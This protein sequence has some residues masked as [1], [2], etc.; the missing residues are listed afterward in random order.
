MN[1]LRLLAV[2]ALAAACSSTP[3]DDPGYVQCANF[4]SGPTV[5]PGEP[6]PLGFPERGC[7]PDKDG[8]HDGSYY[9]CCSDDPAHAGLA[10]A[11][12]DSGMCV[13]V[14]DIPAGSGLAPLNCPIAC[15][16]LASEQEIADVC[17]ASRVCCQTREL[18]PEDCVFDEQTDSLRALT[19]EEADYTL[20]TERGYCMA[21][22]PGQTCP[23]E[24][25]SYR[26]ICERIDAG[27][28]DP[29]E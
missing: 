8:S 15:N 5:G 10:N 16:P 6:G 23:G 17:G 12:S 24:Q 7:R 29:P 26:D 20:A 4:S 2:V 22:A 27:E 14:D 25:E 13:R 3:G 9:R 11:E 18:E 21:L 1:V 19:P 28:V